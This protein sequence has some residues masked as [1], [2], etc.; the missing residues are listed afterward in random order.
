MEEK[1]KWWLKENRQSPLNLCSSVNT[2]TWERLTARLCVSDGG[3][4]EKERERD[5]V[6]HGVTG[7]EN[8][9]RPQRLWF[10]VWL[11]IQS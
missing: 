3:E 9:L 6:T 5:F 10:L 11:H 2:L 8:Q 4:R 7:T 1:R